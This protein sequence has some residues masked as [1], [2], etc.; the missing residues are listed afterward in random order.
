MK[1]SFFKNQNDFRQWLDEHHDTATE[2][3]VGF[4]KVNS[5]KPSMSW[6]ESVDQALCYGWIDGIVKSL[7]DESYSRRFTPRKP[8]SIWSLINIRKAE[9]L[10]SEGLIK[11]AG[12]KAFELR[13][14][15]KSGIYSFENETRELTKDFEKLF[16][17]NEKAW[18]FFNSQ[19]AS[20]IKHILHW[21]VTAKQQ[22][23]QLSRLQKIIDASEQHLRLQ[24]Y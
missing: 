8:G 21:I 22:K 12:L 3:V 23:T 4:Y 6:S 10:I 11:P 1:P 9:Q 7:D 16:K 19:S 2:L 5:G 20:Y 17:A 15:E 14:K 13:T 18:L 24:H